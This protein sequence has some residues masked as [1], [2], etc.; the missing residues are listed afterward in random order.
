MTTTERI[1]QAK[2]AAQAA[3]EKS[4]GSTDTLAPV[5]VRLMLSDATT[6]NDTDAAI[7][8]QRDLEA[9]A[10]RAFEETERLDPS[11]E[12]ALDA[13]DLEI[14]RLRAMVSVL[15]FGIGAWSDVM[16]AERWAQI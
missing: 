13:L 4:A 9:Q 1:A 11:F 14:A 7:R 16:D 3:I 10:D 5:W 12:A 2:A 6:W 8:L 15:G